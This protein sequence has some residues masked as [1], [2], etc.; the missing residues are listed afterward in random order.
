M[1]FVSTKLVDQTEGRQAGRCHC[2]F[3]NPSEC[4]NTDPSLCAGSLSWKRANKPFSFLEPPESDL[5]F[6][7]CRAP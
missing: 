5:I 4:E 6:D 2:C 1:V 7:S 3:S